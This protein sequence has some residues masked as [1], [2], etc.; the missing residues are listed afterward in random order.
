MAPRFPLD[1]AALTPRQ[2]EAHDRIVEARGGIGGPYVPLLTIPDLAEAVLAVGD[3]IR[4]ASA[5]PEHVAELA[6]LVAVRH[7]EAR[8]AWV[9]HSRLAVRAGLPR[10]VVD[11]IGEGRE[12]D[13][14]GDRAGDIAIAHRFCRAL[15]D[16]GR[17]PDDVFA[18]ARTAFGE[19]GTVALTATVGFYSLISLVLNVD[20]HPPPPGTTAPF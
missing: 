5:L 8:Y 15:V 3:Q 10:D 9:A 17:V 13:L 11:A 18:E 6:V 7:W 4:F 16:T 1:V 12:P 14:G 19:A 20:E 2:R